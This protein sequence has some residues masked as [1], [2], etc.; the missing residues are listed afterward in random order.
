MAKKQLANCMEQNTQKWKKK[1][2]S[3]NKFIKLFSF[4]FKLKS[5]VVRM[6]TPKEWN[7]SAFQTLILSVAPDNETDLFSDKENA[8]DRS[9]SGK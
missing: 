6:L 7:I 3:Y 9:I 2:N 4:C 8:V 5:N 1:Q